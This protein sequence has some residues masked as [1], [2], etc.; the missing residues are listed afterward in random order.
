VRWTD[1]CRVPYSCPVPSS[2]AR[3]ARADAGSNFIY[4]FRDPSGTFSEYYSDMDCVPEDQVWTPE[5]FEGA[6]PVA[7]TLLPTLR[8]T[9]ERVTILAAGKCVAPCRRAVLRW[10]RRGKICPLYQEGGARDV[11]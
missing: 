11:R 2:T 1:R 4:Y 9:G 6:M 10:A 7:L 5:T 8:A 3:L